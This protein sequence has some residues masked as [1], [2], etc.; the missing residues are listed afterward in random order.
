M[1]DKALDNLCKGNGLGRP[2]MNPVGVHRRSIVEGDH[3]MRGSLFGMDQ[4]QVT[5]FSQLKRYE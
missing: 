5:L 4:I 3:T 1:K 2:A